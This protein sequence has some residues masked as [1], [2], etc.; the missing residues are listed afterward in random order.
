[1]GD[2]QDAARVTWAT[3]KLTQVGQRPVSLDQLATHVGLPVAETARLVRLIWGERLDLRDGMVRLDATP[4]GPRR[5]RVTP[6]GG[7]SGRAR[8]AAWTCTCWPWRSA[9]RS[10]P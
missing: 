6:A 9:A 10:R 8:A 1:M 5:Y 2:K 7:R 3:I 4:S